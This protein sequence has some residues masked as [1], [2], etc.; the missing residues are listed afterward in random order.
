MLYISYDIYIYIRPKI[1]N[2]ALECTGMFLHAVGYLLLGCTWMHWDALGCISV[3]QDA[4][5]C[6]KMNWDAPVRI[7]LHRVALLRCV[8]IHWDLLH[9]V[10]YV[11][12]CML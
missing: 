8:K 7:R 12:L 9:S 3:H 2:G 5:G 4:A 10:L 11:L 1:H 6:V